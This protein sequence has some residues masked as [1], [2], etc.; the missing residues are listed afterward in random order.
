MAYR[1]R[2]NQNLNDQADKL[3]TL[4][5]DI[6]IRRA[7]F[8]GREFTREADGR[9]YDDWRNELTF[10]DDGIPHIAKPPTPAYTTHSLARGLNRDIPVRQ[11]FMDQWI[12]IG[13]VVSLYGRPGSRKSTLLLQWMIASQLGMGFGPVERLLKG[14]CYGLFCEDD[15]DEILR[16]ARDIL[17][18][19][20]ASFA[21]MS[22][23]HAESLIG[24]VYKQFMAFKRSGVMTPTP[25]WE[26]FIEDLDRIQPIFV[27][28][29][30]ASD[31]F[32]GN[33]ISRTESAAFMGLLDKTANERQFALVCSFH[34][35]LRGL[36]DRSLTSGST[37]WEGKAR[38]RLTIEDPTD[39]DDDDD[40]P[41]TNQSDR[42]TLTLA[43]ANYAKSGPTIDLTILNG[44]FIPAALDPNNKSSTPGDN[45]AAERAFLDR[46]KDRLSQGRYVSNSRTTAVYAPTILAD[47]AFPFRTL[48]NAMNRLFARGVLKFIGK[49]KG[50]DRW[51]ITAE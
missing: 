13:Q 35:S 16:R 20:N 33:E 27:C 8:Q 40:T 31:F 24:T 25:V 48:E 6:Q 9:W 45:A 50:I 23:C 43:K 19:Y 14:P 22:D 42:R 51:I 47:K 39:S 5:N 11:W 17:S 49:N 26:K 18:G 21:D 15:E 32:G 3:R 44:R 10:S 34:P 29:D 1:S 12:P 7:Q 28:L 4:E 36:R 46:L 30:V 41:Q 37:G 2:S 38:A